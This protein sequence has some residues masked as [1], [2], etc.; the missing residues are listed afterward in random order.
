LTARTR[1]EGRARSKPYD[2]MNS[3]EPIHEIHNYDN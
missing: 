2:T 3:I 1:F